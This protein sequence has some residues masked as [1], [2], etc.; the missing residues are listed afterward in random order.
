MGELYESMSEHLIVH[1]KEKELSIKQ[2]NV[3]HL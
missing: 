1:L 3:W 2:H